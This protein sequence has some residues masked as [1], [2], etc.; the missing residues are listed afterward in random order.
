M[1]ASMGAKQGD[2]QWWKEKH[3][4]YCYILITY[5]N[6]QVKHENKQTKNK[7][8]KYKKCVYIIC[9]ERPEFEKKN[10]FGFSKI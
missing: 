9:T 4:Q 3:Q 1:D 10:C 5:F 6:K 8:N 2:K 7:Q